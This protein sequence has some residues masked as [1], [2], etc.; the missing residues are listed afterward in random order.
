MVGK[1]IVVVANLAPRKI[2]GIES[3]GMLLA[4]ED[5]QGKL[6]VVELHGEGLNGRA[7]K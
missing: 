5:A 3:H 6:N 2:R 4:V 1:N 7:V